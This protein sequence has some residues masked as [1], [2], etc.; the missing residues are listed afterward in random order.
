MKVEPINPIT[1]TTFMTRNQNRN[2]W[3]QQKNKVKV[4]NEDTGIT[5]DADVL[6]RTNDRLVLAINT[7][8]VTL[9]KN[10]SGM[11]VGKM[12]GMSLKSDG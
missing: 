4:I 11:Y 10:A 9:A 5:V 2:D 7:V 6:S 12:L 1:R 8:K 3:N